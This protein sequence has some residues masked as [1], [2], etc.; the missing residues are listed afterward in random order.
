[1][2]SG[3]LSCFCSVAP[4]AAGAVP[5]VPSPKPTTKAPARAP[6]GLHEVSPAP[7]GL[8]TAGTPLQT[9]AFSWESIPA[10]SRRASCAR[11]ARCVLQALARRGLG[12]LHFC[13]RFL[14][15]G[16]SQVAQAGAEHSWH[17]AEPGLSRAGVWLP[18]AGTESCPA[19]PWHLPPAP[20]G[21]RGGRPSP[22][23]P[24]LWRARKAQQ[25][26]F[27]VWND[28][29]GAETAAAWRKH[30]VIPPL[31]M[32]ESRNGG[33]FCLSPNSPEGQTD[34]SHEVPHSPS[35]VHHV[36][37]PEQRLLKDFG[38]SHCLQSRISL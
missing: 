28:G 34:Q 10:S 15:L 32:S 20:A 18:R 23:A 14:G 31:F 13:C 1:M 30:S 37:V 35:P 21:P 38:F 4:W 3:E 17:R 22:A 8:P 26:K 24:E 33:E 19:R 27:S 6:P 5:A 16:S 2:L 12:L 11:E 36:P 7:G 29:L 25:E 9:P